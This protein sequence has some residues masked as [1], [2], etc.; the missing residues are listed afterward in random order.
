MSRRK[1]PPAT[2]TPPGGAP[3]ET[4]QAGVRAPEGVPPAQPRSLRRLA[5][6][7]GILAAV[8][9]VAV[10][11]AELAGAANLGVAIG[12]G[13]LAFPIALVALLLRA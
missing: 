6:D 3:D 2:S 12:I 10:G 13:Q 8:F 11:I 7:F 5:I 9:A 1:R 4:P